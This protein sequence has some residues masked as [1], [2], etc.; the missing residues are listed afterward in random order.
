M[1]IG[2]HIHP[3]ETGTIL[4]QLRRKVIDVMAEIT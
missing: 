2:F 4:K 3:I 1:D